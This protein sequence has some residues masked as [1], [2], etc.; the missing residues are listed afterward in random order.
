MY[1]LSLS[2]L[3]ICVSPILLA[4]DYIVTLQKDTIKGD[5]SIPLPK[6]FMEE[7]RIETSDTKNLYKAHQVLSVF[8][9]STFY[10]PV[11]LGNKYRL[12]EVAESGYLTLYLYRADLSY[13]F[14][15]YYLQ[16]KSLE[17]LE[18]PNIS[19][20][21]IMSTYL[22]NC[23]TVVEK[24]EN[25]TLR[26]DDLEQIVKEYN[27][28]L[29]ERTELIYEGKIDITEEATGKENNDE[30]KENST[31]ALI[32]SIQASIDGKKNTELATLLAD[33]KDKVSN[34]EPVPGYLKSALKEQT[35]G[36]TAI[37]KE[38]EELLKAIN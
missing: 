6:E 37:E 22:E 29:K 4:Q 28:C 36:M 15:S 1:K 10:E 30:I 12:M 32:R 26:R 31:V 38:V 23:P 18:V 2:L 9:D 25:K 34:N 14:N 20:K 33:I 11:K 17:G 7:V 16:K 5:V 24:I 13:D 21:R 35:A 19:F 8:T 27:L 3:L